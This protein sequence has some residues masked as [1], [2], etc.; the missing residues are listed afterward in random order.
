MFKPIDL[1]RIADNLCGWSILVWSLLLLI[2]T[3][4]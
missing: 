3:T 2:I 4:C 1:K